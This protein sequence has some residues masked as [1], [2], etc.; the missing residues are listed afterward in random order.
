MSRL[1]G[2]I[3][4]GRHL[5]PLLMVGLAIAAVIVTLPGLRDQ[6]MQSARVVSPNGDS[7]W[8]SRGA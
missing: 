3:R 7:E 1:A 4:F 8:D 2:T 5:L 6:L